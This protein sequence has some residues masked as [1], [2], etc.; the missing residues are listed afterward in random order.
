MRQAIRLPDALQP[1]NGSFTYSGSS[2]VVTTLDG[3]DCVGTTLTGTLA[4]DT[5][6]IRD[7]SGETLVYRR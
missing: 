4:G 5:L 3:Q 2:L 1:N 6:T 7:G